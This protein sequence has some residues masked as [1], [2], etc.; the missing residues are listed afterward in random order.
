MKI[1]IWGC[2]GSLSTPGITTLR[3]GGNTTCVEVRSKEG[4]VIVVDA[5][6]GLRNLGKVL[7]K[8]ENITDIHML[9]THSHWDHLVGFPFF[10]PAWFDRY[11][12]TICGGPNA[13]DSL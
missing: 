1:K 3:Y 11:K 12:I 7:V 5:G 8:E 9:I 6:S 13:E 2:R 10:A 4:D